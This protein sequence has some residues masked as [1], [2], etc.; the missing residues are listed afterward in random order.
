MSA[1]GKVYIV[2]EPVK[3]GDDG[4]W[5]KFLDFSPASAYGNLEVLLPSSDQ[6]IVGVNPGPMMRILKHGLRDF[7]D[8]DSL[9]LAGDPT[10]MAAAAMVAAHNNRGRVHVLRWNNET[11][12]YIRVALDIK[13]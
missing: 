3:K 8:L 13:S 12:Q 2:Q 6:F 9:C 4:Q 5:R 11:R 7:C 1:K 10:A